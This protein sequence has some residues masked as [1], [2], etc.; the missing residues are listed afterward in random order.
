MLRVYIFLRMMLFD[1]WERDCSF[2]GLLDI[3]LAVRE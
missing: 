2:F 1:V 3:T